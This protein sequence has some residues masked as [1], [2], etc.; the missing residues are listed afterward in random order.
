MSLISTVTLHLT[1]SRSNGYLC[2]YNGFYYMDNSIDY[3]SLINSLMNSNKLHS[4]SLIKSNK[5]YSPHCFRKSIS[6]SVPPIL[7]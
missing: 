2:M 5:L 7:L 6:L 4:V 1:T 3:V